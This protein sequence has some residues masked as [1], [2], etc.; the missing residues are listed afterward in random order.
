M[1]ARLFCTSSDPQTSSLQELYGNLQPVS[2]HDLGAIAGREWKTAVKEL[3]KK[4][5]A[6]SLELEWL[7]E[8]EVTENEEA[9][10]LVETRVLTAPVGEGQ[11]KF[12]LR[13]YNR[14]G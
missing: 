4:F 13:A 11:E 9:A 5:S 2:I 6:E 3:H 14:L 8:D 10:N 12:Q 7:T 1:T